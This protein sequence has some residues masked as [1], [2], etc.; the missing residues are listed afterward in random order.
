[1]SGVTVPVL[2]FGIRPRGPRTC[3]NWPTTRIASGEATTTSKSIMPPLICSARSSMPTKVSAPAA[4]A[5][6]AAFAPW[7][8]TAT[9][10][11][12]PVP[13]GSVVAPRTAWS[14]FL[15]SIP[16][17][18]ATSTVSLNLTV[19]K[20]LQ[21]AHRLIEGISLFRVASTFSLNA[22]TRFDSLAMI[23]SPPLYFD[24][25][26]CG[27]CRRWCARRRPYRR[28]SGPATSG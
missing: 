21:Q 26:S 4:L 10:T 24:T 18:T 6:S 27:R 14:D 28:P 25:R 1:M 13:W 23:S 17:L 20:L 7:V 2:G 16:R 15:A 12:E 8:N 19:A 11:S 9:R 5:L 22:R 3:P